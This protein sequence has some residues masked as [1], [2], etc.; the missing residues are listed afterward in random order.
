MFAVMQLLYAT[1]YGNPARPDD[2]YE[3][4]EAHWD[5]ERFG[6]TIYEVHIGPAHSFQESL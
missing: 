4:R 2:G 5:L 6:P 1:G 3:S